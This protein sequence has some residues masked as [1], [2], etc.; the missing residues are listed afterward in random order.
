MLFTAQVCFVGMSNIL[1]VVV[2]DC[3]SYLSYQLIPY[4]ISTCGV[5]LFGDLGSVVRIRYDTT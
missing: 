2:V 5:L 1:V 4:I 3:P